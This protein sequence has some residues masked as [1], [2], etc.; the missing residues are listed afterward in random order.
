MVQVTIYLEESIEEKMRSAAQ[1]AHISQSK[2]IAGVIEDKISNVWPQS[3][4][5]L[6]G[7]WKDFPTAEE[8]RE[9][10]G[11]DAPREEL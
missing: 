2:W 5:D 9:E 7:A 1:S 8:L 10:A 4:I 11:I 6:S 3:I